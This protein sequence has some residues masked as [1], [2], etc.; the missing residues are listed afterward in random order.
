MVNASGSTKVIDP[1]FTLYGPPGLDVGSLLSGFVLGAIH[2]A[3]MNNTKAV[4][5]IVRGAKAIW[6]SY[7]KAL[8]EEGLS[9]DLIKSIE[10]ESVG[11]TVQE[12]CRT[13]LEFAGGRKWL[14]FEDPDT[15]IK[16][17][18]AALQVVDRCMIARH[19]GGIQLMLDEMKK[20]VV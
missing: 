3:Y 1:E 16:A 4:E 18:K 6:D 8:K 19:E 2:Q 20:V 10:I 9:D 12:V 14:Q 13:A 7:S 15:K 11:F 17:R 5:D